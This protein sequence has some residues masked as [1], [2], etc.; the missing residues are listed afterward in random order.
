MV[1]VLSLRTL[2]EISVLFDTIWNM[3][4]VLLK[5]STVVE[6]TK[7]SYNCGIS[8]VLIKFKNDSLNWSFSFLFKYSF[9]KWVIRMLVVKLMIDDLCKIIK[10]RLSSA[11]LP[12]VF[13]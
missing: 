13:S 6:L 11:S 8:T 12:S 9:K 4:E 5:I 10:L 2:R 3:L 7:V 1:N